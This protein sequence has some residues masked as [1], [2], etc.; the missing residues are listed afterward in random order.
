M[1]KA[2]TLVVLHHLILYTVTLFCWM[3]SNANRD[4]LFVSTAW[5]IASKHKIKSTCVVHTCTVCVCVHSHLSWGALLYRFDDGDSVPLFQGKAVASITGPYL[6]KNDKSPISKIPSQ[7]TGTFS[8]STKTHTH[9]RQILVQTDSS[10]GSICSL[11]W[12]E[13]LLGY[14]MDF[15]SVMTF[16]SHSCVPPND[17]L[18]LWFVL[19]GGYVI[20]KSQHLIQTEI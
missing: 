8:Q 18:C 13:C 2:T 3:G 5:K 7:Q 19:S 4:F 16:P 20:A 10:R 9:Q 6:G 17:L 1:E 15:C 12:K 11:L 14:K